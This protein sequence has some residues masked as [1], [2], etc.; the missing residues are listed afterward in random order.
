MKEWH[1]P[2]TR[3]LPTRSGR[4]SSTRGRLQLLDT[5]GHIGPKSYKTGSR[6][7]TSGGTPSEP[8]D[9]TCHPRTPK[10]AG[11]RGVW[12]RGDENG[13]PRRH[14]V[15]MNHPRGQKSTG[16]V[17]VPV[18]TLAEMGID[19][20]TGT[21][22][23]PVS[24]PTL[25]DRQIITTV[26]GRRSGPRHRRVPWVYRHSGPPDYSPPEVSPVHFRHR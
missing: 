9:Q 18:E 16:T 7:G 1:D 5:K 19:K 26:D 2:A 6:K 25:A 17:L 3:N 10:R 11:A 12:G 24:E 8:P 21:P 20:K 13:V 14:P 22:S 15:L 4:I 23:V